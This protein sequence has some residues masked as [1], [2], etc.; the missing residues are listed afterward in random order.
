MIGRRD[1]LALGILG[2]ASLAPLRTALA[3]ADC[4]S[5]ERAQAVGTALLDKYVAAVNAHDTSSFPEIHTESYIQH[6][7]RSPNGLAAQIE[8]FRGIFG[9]M[10]DVQ[11][12]VEDRIIAGDR[13]VARMSFSATHTQ[14]LQGIAPTGRRFTLRTIDIW[15]VENGKF[16][17]HW[18]IVDVPGLQRQLRGEQ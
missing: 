15:R 2:A 7:G 6:S 18:D 12:R 9:R 17:E 13:V 11:A 1:M 14:P 8:N 10:P 4:A 3:A 16:A 5:A